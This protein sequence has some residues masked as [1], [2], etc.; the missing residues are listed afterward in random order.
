MAA[1]EIRKK[2][3]QVNDTGHSLSI[4]LVKAEGFTP[5]SSSDLN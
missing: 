1:N 3:A 5:P 4:E 2:C